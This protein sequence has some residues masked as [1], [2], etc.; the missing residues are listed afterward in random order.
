VV[1]VKVCFVTANYPPEARGGTEQVVVALARELTERG[2]EVSAISGSDVR[3]EDADAD[4]LTERCKDV[5]VTRIFRAADE[6]DQQGFERPRIL[7][8]IRS[9][10]LELKPDVVHVHSFAGLTLGIGAI[11][12]EL[13][14]PMV[15]TFHDM[16]VTCARYFRLPAAGVTCPTGADHAAC[17][18]CV[19]DALQSDREHVRQALSM[20]EEL[21]RSELSYASACTAPSA[22]AATLVRECI[23]YTDPIEVVPHGLLR[24]VAREHQAPS[25][26]ATEPVRVGTFGGLVESKGLTEL[27]DACLQVTA[28]GHRCELHLAGPWHEQDLAV[29]LREKA[30]GGGLELIEHGPFTAADPHPARRLHLAVFPSKCQETYGLVVDEA[31]AHGVPVVVSN[32][33]ALAERSATPGVVVTP[34][35]GLANT[36]LKLIAFPEELSLLRQQIP[37][38]LPA[39]GASAQRH[40]DLYQSLR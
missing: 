7:Q 22:T 31:L 6:H 38:E 8:L 27:V 11:C 19:N 30:R 3:R 34:L 28:K 37:A 40:F 32:S 9:R 33:G 4:V 2:V 35:E 10:L 24:E 23:P 36:L 25:A 29:G 14:T 1:F 26:N 12:R 18:T 15:V 20:R 17:V 39:I 5:S 16:W 13:Q 21:V